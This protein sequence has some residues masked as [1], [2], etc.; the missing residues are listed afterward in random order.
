MSEYTH[1]AEH[2]ADR[3]TG[4]RHL[5]HRGKLLCGQEIQSRHAEGWYKVREWPQCPGC[6]EEAR[7]AYEP[8]PKATECRVLTP[9]EVFLATANAIAAGVEGPGPKGKAWFDAFYGMF[10][11]YNR[12]RT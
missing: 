2:S 6:L 4:T 5:R 8:M 9:L 11:Y 12:H 1:H 10:P 7:C 3:T